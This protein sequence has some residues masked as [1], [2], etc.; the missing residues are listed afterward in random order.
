MGSLERYFSGIPVINLNAVVGWVNDPAEYDARIEQE[1]S[2][3]NQTPFFWYVDEDGSPDFM[4][5]LKKHGFADAGIFRGVLGPLDQPI[6]ST[7][8]P[9]GCV[10]ERV[11]DE[12][13][14]DEFNDLVCRVFEFNGV[15]KE[16]Y[17]DILWQLMQEDNW[18]HWVAR[19]DGQV[20][21]AVS[22]MLKDGIVSFWNGASL[23]ELRKQGLSTALSRLALQHAMANG[24][25]FGSSYLMAEGLAFGICSK[26]GAQTKWRF[27]AF[28]SPQP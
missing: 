28:V 3:F 21:S 9:E 23:P 4:E 10:L 25:R 26:L 27:H 11:E 13:S 1:L 18:I 19:K 14:L 8:I 6:A 5:A 20:V 16:T 7:P 24:A 17:R 2:F 12:K 15:V 22:T